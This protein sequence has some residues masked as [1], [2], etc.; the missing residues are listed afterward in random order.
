MP[1]EPHPSL[2][3]LF[4]KLSPLS[5][6]ERAAR[7]AALRLPADLREEL[8]SLLD[9]MAPASGV[10][11]S[12]RTTVGDPPP[13]RNASRAP[14][15]EALQE[16]GSYK[17]IRELGRGAQGVVFLAEHKVIH[18]R[19]ALKMLSS[20][21]TQSD[22]IRE[23]FRREAE[24]TSRLSHAGICGIYE[25]GEEQGVPF[26]AMQLIDGVPLEKALHARKVGGDEGGLAEANAIGLGGR[27][28]PEIQTLLRFF[29]RAA[30]ALHVAHEAGLVHRDI[31]PGNIMV[32]KSGEPIVVDFGAARDLDAIGH[33]LTQE[34]TLVGTP[35]YMAPEQIR[36]N[37]GG[38]DRRADIYGL[39][40]SLY[41]CL[42]LQRP[43]D[44]ESLDELFHKIQT[45]V[46][47][48]PRK[49]NPIV[50]RDLEVVIEVGLERE[51]DRR[52]PTAE[53]LAEDLQRVATQQKVS[54]RAAGLVRRLKK[55][56]RANPVQAIAA[57]A[58]LLFV[59]SGLGVWAARVRERVLAV[60]GHVAEAEQL[61]EQGNFPAAFEAIAKA[62]ERDPE[63][64]E[65][66]ELRSRAELA[67]ERAAREARRRTDLAAAEA[68]LEEAAAVLARYESARE[69]HASLG[70][71]IAAQRQEVMS[72]YASDERRAAFA[73]EEQKV[74]DLAL[75]QETLLATAREALDRG[76]RLESP[77]L[78]ARSAAS[79][80]ALA[81]YAMR[82]WRRA[83]AAGDEAEAASLRAEVESFDREQR[84]ARELLG[85]GTLAIELAP[86]D[87]ELFLFRCESRER[88]RGSL[89]VPRLV[90][91]PTRGVGRSREAAWC[92]GFFPGDPC[93][94]V[95]EVDADSHAARA[96]LRPGDLVIA[97][98]GQ[99]CGD[100]LFL[101]ALGKDPELARTLVPW[102]RLVAVNGL[103][104]ADAFD[105]GYSEIARDPARLDLD[106]LQLASRAEPLLLEKSSLEWVRPA[107][108]ARGKGPAELRLRCLRNGEELELVVPANEPSGLRTEATAYPLIFSAANRIEPSAALEVDP[109]AYL[110]V[111]RKQDCATLRFSCSVPALGAARAQLMLLPSAA[112]PPGFVHVPAGAV[113]LG[114]DLE[115]RNSPPEQLVEVGDFFVARLEVTNAEWYAFVNDPATLAL[116]AARGERSFVPR[117]PS[118]LMAKKRED[119]AGY[120]PARGRP[121]TAVYGISHA[122]ARAFV[123]WKNAEAE[124]ALSPWVFDLPSSAEWEKAA[125]GGDGRT[126]PWGSRFDPS[127]TVGRHRKATWLLDEPAGAEL[128]DES[129][130]GIRDLGGSRFEWTS[131]EV[132][133]AASEEQREFYYRSGSWFV[134]TPAVFRAA[135]RFS[136][137]ANAANGSTGLRLVARPRRS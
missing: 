15:P 104:I 65:P 130:Y 12:D 108:A 47:A 29:E 93:L 44:A 42:T 129:P 97:L 22:A 56:A 132:G 116:I 19:V 100:G 60:R 135:A 83:K 23:R 124:R 111:A 46:A 57:A 59:L 114:G 89:V 101:R 121:D 87:A 14:L 134:D 96:G 126:Y 84:H 131:E 66:R 127:L 3:E 98:N 102:D 79:D 10:P 51:V 21:A 55:W 39:T 33:T 78:E 73:A 128:G 7:L 36:G 34:G 113:L 20:A 31:K 9:A 99:P 88:L 110:L 38:V 115:A 4:A 109:G 2:E 122:D 1:P 86:S 90:P 74:K 27:S 26:I 28:W 125:R 8:E 32:T 50:T 112:V 80:A 64:P 103:P 95:L 61:I 41:E 11:L 53:A 62:L 137:N 25:V 91:V 40:A 30:R 76:V 13:A 35:A 136:G 37:R 75:A 5:A 24:I 118:K 6:A 18:R 71:S 105:W 81:D 49:L 63:N 17:L 92:E 69:E 48:S 85:R 107:V 94:V 68:A 133:K 117:E 70:L 67:Q 120:E 77:W 58:L 106:R 82:L 43:F 123:A 119:G 54:A 72:A 16:F 45:K 52:Y